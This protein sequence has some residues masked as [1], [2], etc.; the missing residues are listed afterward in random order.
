MKTTRMSLLGK[1]RSVVSLPRYLEPI[2]IGS[3]TPLLV[4]PDHVL[5]DKAREL[6]VER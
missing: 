3:D 4:L 5:R 2:Q 1:N 6:G